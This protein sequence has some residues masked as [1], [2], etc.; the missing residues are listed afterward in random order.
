MQGNE[1]GR[2]WFGLQPNALGRIVSRRGKQV[3]RD[4]F[5]TVTPS[6]DQHVRAYRRLGGVLDFV[7]GEWLLLGGIALASGLVFAFLLLA[8]EV[9]EGGTHTFDNAVL[10]WFREP[11]NAADPIGPV[12]LE[13][14]V[15]DVTALGSFA[16]LSLLVA[17]V[18]LYLLLARMRGAAVLVAVSVLGGTVISTVLKAFYDRPRPD[19]VHLAREFSAS[20][21]SGH[22]M[23]SAVTYLTLG[24]LLARLAPT[25][26]LKVFA[27][28]VAVLLTLMIGTSRMYLGV[29]YP[30]DVMAGWCLGAAWALL[31]STIAVR[32]QRRGSVESG[33]SDP[34]RPVLEHR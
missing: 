22:S 32:L 10:L 3:Q 6:S 20:F 29:H 30:S 26:P 12:R 28:V 33:P 21:P 9:V 31:C 1:F 5:V 17:G 34:S 2:T 25:G 4:S 15:R 23:L 24:A 19:L 18:V 16:I 13:E 7:R 27:L 8:D 14:M 11:G